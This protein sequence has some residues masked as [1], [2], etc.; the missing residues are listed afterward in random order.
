M[1]SR[2]KLISSLLAA[3]A[4]IPARD[5]EAA[6]AIFQAAG[7]NP[8]GTPVLPQITRQ[9]GIPC[10]M[11][12]RHP[13][14]RG[15]IW[16][17]W[18]TGLGFYVLLRDVGSGF[19]HGLFPVLQYNT[20]GQPGGGFFDNGP[21]P[22]R[23]GFRWGSACQWPGGAQEDV[24]YGSGGV[25]L[26]SY[27]YD[28]ADPIR[29][30]QNLSVLATGFGFTMG[31]C[32]IQTLPSKTGLVVGRIIPESTDYF[33]LRN[34]GTSGSD[35]TNR[36]MVAGW[37]DGSNP[38]SIIGTSTPALG[39]I[40]VSFFTAFNTGSGVSTVQLLVNGNIENSATGQTIVDLGSGS[41]IEQNEGQLNIGQF[42]HITANHSS[43][44]WGGAVP[45]AGVWGRRVYPAE[46]LLAYAS[47]RDLV[48]W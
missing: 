47:P 5:A 48:V 21:L 41:G 29:V 13:L 10:G 28:G 18:D 35:Q 26:T 37:Y 17:A 45:W 30:A 1:L 9:P 40:N 43:L 22:A 12:P 11:N 32:H 8:G 33:V 4:I 19:G 15:C 6:F 20:N 39:S 23:G 24:A 16:F 44:M 31:G 36:K 2:R 38:Q 27:I 46:A 42:S 25:A 34:N 3:P 7:V 14:Y